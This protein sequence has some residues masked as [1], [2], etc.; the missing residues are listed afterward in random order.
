MLN[1]FFVTSVK[2]SSDDQSIGI[3]SRE[4][5]VS[6]WKFR[7]R[8]DA[9]RLYGHTNSISSVCFSIDGKLLVS[10]SWD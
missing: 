1:N 10:G 6:L 2:F 7:E 4:K 3:G 5:I 8:A 9:N